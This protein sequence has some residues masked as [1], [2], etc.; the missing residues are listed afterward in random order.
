MANKVI[1]CASNSSSSQV[2]A[3]R[4][5]IIGLGYTAVLIDATSLTLS[6][7]AAEAAGGHV[8]CAVCTIAHVESATLAANLLSI[9]N[10]G[11]PVI[12][13][14]AQNVS[15]GTASIVNVLGL[16]T[17]A[18]IEV[19]GAGTNLYVVSNNSILVNSSGATEGAIINYRA[20]NTYINHLQTTGLHASVKKLGLNNDAAGKNILLYVN[21]ASLTH[22]ISS[23]AATIIFAGMLWS[24][25]YTAQGKLLIDDMINFCVKNTY[26]KFQVSGFVRD[27]GNNPLERM[28][29]A[30]RRSDGAFLAQT[31]SNQAGEY[32]FLLASG[33]AVSVM[34]FQDEN[35]SKNALIKDR[36]IP[37]EL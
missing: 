32:E 15:A 28:L 25:S 8:I 10:A 19:D 6:A 20:D 12:I 3:F 21:K 11:Y 24:T 4:D 13:G 9:N 1:I 35:E 18:S 37:V 16:T 22:K 30:Y 17:A 2:V 5:V 33:D 29:R 26:T 27:A 14:M 34:C 31:Q 23:T 7:V 36:I